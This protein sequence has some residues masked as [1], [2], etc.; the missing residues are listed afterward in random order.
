VTCVFIDTNS[1][2]LHFIE[3]ISH[4]MLIGAKLMVGLPQVVA[5][6]E[7]TGIEVFVVDNRRSLRE[8]LQA[9]LRA[10]T[11]RQGEAKP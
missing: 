7:R 10:H 2:W 9:S 5:D 11:K 3:S 8:S 6:L 1:F 4:G